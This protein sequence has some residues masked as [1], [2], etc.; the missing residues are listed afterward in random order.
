[1]G[2]YLEL[3]RLD[4]QR[5]GKSV[6]IDV[7][8]EDDVVLGRGP[9]LMLTDVA[10]SRRLVRVFFDRAERIWSWESLSEAQPAYYQ[11]HGDWTALKVDQ[12]IKLKT[13]MRVGL[14]PN[15]Y[16][17]KV[18]LGPTQDPLPQTDPTS[19]AASSRRLPKWLNEMVHEK[20]KRSQSAQSPPRATKSEPKSP[21]SE[22]KSIKSEPKSTNS[23]E[24]ST[25]FQPM[26]NP[27]S[28]KVTKSEPKSS[29]SDSK[30][31]ELVTKAAPASKTLPVSSKKAAVHPISDDSAESGDA[32]PE[33]EPTPPRQRRTRKAPRSPTPTSSDR[34]LSELDGD[35]TE[36]E[37]APTPQPARSKSQKKP[38]ASQPSRS[39]TQAVSEDEEATGPARASQ[40][41]HAGARSKGQGGGV[42]KAKSARPVL[43]DE[44]EDDDK[45]RAK[46]KTRVGRGQGRGQSS[47]G[48]PPT[49]ASK[50]D[51]PDPATVAKTP[52]GSDQPEVRRPRPKCSF[53]PNCY[54]KNP[55]HRRSLSHPGDP[56]YLDGSGSEIPGWDECSRRPG[57]PISISIDCDILDPRTR[58]RTFIMANALQQA[59]QRNYMQDM[60]DSKLERVRPTLGHMSMYVGLVLY[61]S[62]GAY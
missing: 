1:M 30:S 34:T 5:S 7:G 55:H 60:L 12:P 43:S 33:S 28:P 42:K 13:G 58:N 14:L 8:P 10:L 29:K 18:R 44:D 57:Q 62:V 11:R 15:K 39:A 19:E 46:Q 17:Y 45:G 2:P 48:K 50:R 21:N 3:E 22:E 9:M 20:K 38:R 61:T 24:K 35:A 23:D 4:T 49:H 41:G 54:R 47:R 40:T 32:I 52:K 16:Q 26:A 59:L 53:A 27:K 25:K 37:D 56:D 31:A 51:R 36:P 6:R